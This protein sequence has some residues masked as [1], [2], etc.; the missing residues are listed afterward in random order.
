MSATDFVRDAGKYIFPA[1]ADEECMG[2]FMPR[3]I[4]ERAERLRKKKSGEPDP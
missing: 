4:Y 3:T 2:C 1:E